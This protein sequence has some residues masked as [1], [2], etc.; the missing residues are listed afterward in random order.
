MARSSSHSEKSDDLEGHHLSDKTPSFSSLRYL[1]VCGCKVVW[2]ET[3]AQCPQC[4]R[5]L[6]RKVVDDPTLT[7]TF[8]STDA[9]QSGTNPL[10]SEV[11]DPQGLT[12]DF[13]QGADGLSVLSHGKSEL[14]IHA[15]IGARD[16]RR[17]GHFVLEDQLGAG[18]MGAVFRALDTSLQRYVA[19]KVLRGY[20]ASGSQESTRAQNDRL[21]REAVAQARLNHPHVVTI[22]YVGREEEEEPFLA[23]ELL[24]GPTLQQRLTDGPLP[25]VEVVLYALQVISAL[26]AADRSGLIHGDI[27]P[28][29]LL[30]AGQGHVKLGDFGLARRSGSADAGGAVSGTPNYIAPELVDGAAPSRQTDMYALGVTLF[31]LAFGRRPFALTGETLHERLLTHQTAQV[32]YPEKWPVEIP[33]QFQEVLDKLL[34]KTPEERYSTYEKLREDLWRIT[35]IGSTLAGR[36]SRFIAW[37]VDMACLWAIQIPLILPNLIFNSIDADTRDDF[38][39]VQWGV[40]VGGWELLFGLLAMVGLALPPMLGLWWDWKRW[41]TPGRFLMQLRVVDEHGLPP[42]QRV[43]MLRGVLRYF[44]FWCSLFFS[45]PLVLAIPYFT[46]IDGVI[47]RLWLVVDALFVFGAMRRA[48][49]DRICRTHV[50]LDENTSRRFGRSASQGTFLSALLTDGKTIRS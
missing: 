29:N 34:A 33:E 45:I 23:M 4:S 12:V 37:T 41:R 48:L 9:H 40:S 3:Q 26:E 15:G 43:R 20:D 14:G 42:P 16:G 1:C 19:V 11:P 22:Y 30:M 17:L 18:G 8:C 35:P 38:P 32:E 39:G 44:E 6:P 36:L 5:P 46:L 24:P 25:Y 7:L 21:R 50:V 28:S 27:K 13:T 49:H 2:S 10:P 47:G 31:E